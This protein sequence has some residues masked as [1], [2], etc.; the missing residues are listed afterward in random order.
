M[1][2]TLS[3]FNQPYRDYNMI[4][5]TSGILMILCMLDFIY[6]I[7]YYDKIKF[8][9]KKTPFLIISGISG[10]ILLIVSVFM[11]GFRN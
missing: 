10:I 4:V 6:I 8:S 7:M 5:L 3:L 2:Y 11:P 9:I 1:D